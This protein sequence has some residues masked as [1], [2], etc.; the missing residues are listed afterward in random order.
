MKEQKDKLQ[1]SSTGID[2]V[3][4]ESD[5]PGTWQWF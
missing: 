1:L 4:S 3:A 5:G 2:T